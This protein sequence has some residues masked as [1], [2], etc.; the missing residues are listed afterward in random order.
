MGCLYFWQQWIA[1]AWKS[2]RVYTPAVIL[3][4]QEWTDWRS[5][6]LPNT[7][8]I[9]SMDL[10]LSEQTEGKFA[11]TVKGLKKDEVNKFNLY[12]AVLGFDIHSKITDGESKGK[13][14]VH[15][16]IV[17]EWKK[18]ALQSQPEGVFDF[19]D[20]I[21]SFKSKSPRLALVGW[22]EKSDSLEPLQAVGGYL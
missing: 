20:Q 4:S 3:D 13:T 5:K 9:S 22:V 7:E 6:S 18:I 14:L 15:N 16:F 19:S 17:L 2:P 12:V 21:K 11:I 1:K 10:K 8:K